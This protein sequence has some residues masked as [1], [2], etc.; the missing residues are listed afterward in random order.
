MILWFAD[1]FKK[2]LIFKTAY[3]LSLFQKDWVKE[4]LRIGLK[5]D[6]FPIFA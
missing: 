2:E 5:L 1:R 6:I 3:V 4:N